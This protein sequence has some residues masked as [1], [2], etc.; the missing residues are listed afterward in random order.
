VDYTRDKW[1]TSSSLT[2]FCRGAAVVHFSRPPRSTAPLSPVDAPLSPAPR[3]SLGS[4]SVGGEIRQKQA[5]LRDKISE[6]EAT[7]K[8][9]WR[10]SHSGASVMGT[11]GG[12]RKVRR[13]KFIRA[14]PK[15]LSEATSHLDPAHLLFNPSPVSP[16][17][18]NLPPPPGHIPLG[19]SHTHRKHGGRTLRWCRRHRPG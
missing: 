15:F 16:R 6:A 4:E 1:S 3:M 8:F 7:S 14:P 10:P 9:G 5:L 2:W 12:Q 19:N 17:P 18:L 11:P 13:S